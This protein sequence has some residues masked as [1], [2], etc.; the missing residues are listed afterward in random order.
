MFL[1]QSNDTEQSK[2]APVS[3]P[4]KDIGLSFIQDCNYNMNIYIIHH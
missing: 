1:G 2:N 4:L 3:I